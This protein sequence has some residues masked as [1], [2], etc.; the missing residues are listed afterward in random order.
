MIVTTHAKTSCRKLKMFFSHFIIY[1][2]SHSFVYLLIK[3]FDTYCKLQKCD[4]KRDFSPSH[5][6]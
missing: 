2:N 5:N 4:G 1:T 3:L 6:L